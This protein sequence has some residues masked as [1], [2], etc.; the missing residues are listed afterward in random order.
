MYEKGWRLQEQRVQTLTGSE[1]TV[2]KPRQ[3]RPLSYSSSDTR[4]KK[5]IDDQKMKI[6]AMTRELERW[7][8]EQESKQ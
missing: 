1:K 5:I 8:A 4:E 6:E 2:M 3:Q 7:E